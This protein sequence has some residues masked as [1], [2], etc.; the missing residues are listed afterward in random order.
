MIVNALRKDKAIPS[1]RSGHNYQ[2]RL[3]IIGTNCAE[4]GLPRVRE[5]TVKDCEYYLERRKEEVGQSTLDM[6]RIALQLTL[7]HVSGH[8]EK[9]ERLERV[10]SL[11]DE[12]Q[13]SR[14][15]TTE[16]I[17]MVKAR[18][19]E[20]H[21]LNVDIAHACGLRA[22]DLLA[23][24]RIDEKAPDDRPANAEKFLGRPGEGYSVDSKGGLTRAISL[25]LE[26]AQR[27]EKHRLDEPMK[28]MDRGV[29][30]WSNYNVKGGK[31]FSDAF[32]AASKRALGW[33]RGAHGLRHTYAQ[34]RMRELARFGL[35][36]TRALQT[37]SQ[38]MGHF[39]PEITKIY[40]R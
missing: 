24:N 39:R 9:D 4:W 38:E 1:I 20:A 26:L 19:S 12:A 25:P 27:L 7:A 2:E 30:Y 8:L 31:R 33:S 18:M 16:Q 14:F 21:Q 29:V 17:D 5:M 35:S 10:S 34:E 15:Y 37:V 32:A 23:I 11:L 13:G 22:A 36:Y 6:E 40:L 28:V 3:T